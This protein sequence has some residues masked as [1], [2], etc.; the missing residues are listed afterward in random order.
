MDTHL[1]R[2][3]ARVVEE[4]LSGARMEKIQEPQQGILTITFFGKEGKRQLWIRFGRK[5]PFCFVSATRVGA[6]RQPSA[7]VMRLRKYLANRR[8]AAVVSQYCQ[9]KLWIL[10]VS[11]PDNKNERAPWLCLDLANGPSLHFLAPED[12]PQ[13][14]A[15]LWPSMAQLPG[16]LQNWRDWPVLTPALRKTLQSMDAPDQAALVQD[17]QS[18][19]GDVFVYSKEGPDGLES[20]EKVSAWPLPAQMMD[21]CKETCREDILKAMEEA[22]TDLV[23]KKFY[24]ER[25]ERLL[26]PV[27]RRIKNIQKLLA[28]LREDESRL[29]AMKEREKDAL[30]ISE[31]LWRHDRSEHTAR[32]LV[33]EGSH[34]PAREIGLDERLDILQNMERLFHAARRGKRGLEALRE[35]RIALREEL[36]SLEASPIVPGPID[37][38][39]K[40]ENNVDAENRGDMGARALRKNLPANVALYVSSDGYLVMRGKDARGNHAMRRFAS[41]HD[42][43]AH[44]EKGPG[45]H[46]IIRRLH[47]AREIPERTLDEAGGLAASKSW[48]AESGLASVMYAEIRHVK[49]ARKGPP[50]KMIIDKLFLTR[51]VEVSDKLEE[52][53]VQKS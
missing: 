31:N 52:I 2:L 21:D 50:G 41:A 29:Q 34:G 24:G 27:K 20:I 51:N 23:I 28:K 42:L 9:R 1:F 16:A 32:L 6:A 45:A 12:C 37:A 18:G 14:D 46:V 40:P 10:P 38:G 36:E 13:A 4:L 22:G 33:P 43:W 17:L 11:P 8:I 44:V 3:F 5:D 25:E 39:E 19:A 53:I 15:P 26:A 49:P 48:L 30:A 47:P 35:R 7:M